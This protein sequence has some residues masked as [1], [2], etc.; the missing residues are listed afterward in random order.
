MT[1]VEEGQR[2]WIPRDSNI[3]YGFFAAFI[4]LSIISFLTQQQ[5]QQLQQPSPNLKKASEPNPATMKFFAILSIAI[6]LASA[7]SLPNPFLEKRCQ[8]NGGDYCDSAAIRCCAGLYCCSNNGFGTGNCQP[9]G[10][11]GGAPANNCV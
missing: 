10:A 4:S 1:K 5:Q 11:N 9:P 2:P 7:A 6:S 8:G 3:K